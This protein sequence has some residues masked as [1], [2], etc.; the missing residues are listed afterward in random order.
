MG[1]E[2]FDG[3]EI[4]ENTVTL[5]LRRKKQQYQFRTVLIH[6]YNS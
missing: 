2:G 6:L 3:E 1:K 4:F 5:F